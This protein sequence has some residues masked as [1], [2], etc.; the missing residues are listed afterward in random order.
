LEAFYGAVELSR[1]PEFFDLVVTRDE[2]LEMGSNACRRKFRDWKPLDKETKG[3]EVLRGKS[4]GKSKD[5]D[6]DEEDIP[7]R[8]TG[9]GRGRGVGGASTRKRT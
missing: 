8:R 6:D 5:D 9:R 4:S 1:K 2:Y 3:K 7:Q